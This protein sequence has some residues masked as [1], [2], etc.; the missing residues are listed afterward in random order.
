MVR[1]ILTPPD[2][3]PNGI[4]EMEWVR[5]IGTRGV[6]MVESITDNCALVDW[7]RGAKEV[8]PC[9]LLEMVNYGERRGK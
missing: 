3:N 1:P 6:G 4:A 7:L 5:K 8:V 2:P 9:A